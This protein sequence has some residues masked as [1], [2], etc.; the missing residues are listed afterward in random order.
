MTLALTLSTASLKCTY[1][2]TLLHECLDK[3]NSPALQDEYFIY[4]HADY[5]LVYIFGY[6]AGE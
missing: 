2:F 5:S 1:G 4:P 6:E 3:Y